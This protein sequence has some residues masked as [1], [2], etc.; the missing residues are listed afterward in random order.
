MNIVYRLT[1]NN[2]FQQ[3]GILVSSENPKRACHTA[4]FLKDARQAYRLVDFLNREQF[5]IDD[6][7]D[8]YL[9][10]ELLSLL[11]KKKVRP[12]RCVPQTK[13]RRLSSTR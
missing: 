12:R 1:K 13:H 7:C 10:C 8:L 3:Y 11:K 6:F 9:H 4:P 5:P 2:T